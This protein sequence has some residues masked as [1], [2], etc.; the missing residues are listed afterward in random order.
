MQD[1]ADFTDPGGRQ[2]RHTEQAPHSDAQGEVCAPAALREEDTQ[3]RGL[4][5]HKGMERGSSTTRK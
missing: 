4:G 1:M 5:Y 3:R 2:T